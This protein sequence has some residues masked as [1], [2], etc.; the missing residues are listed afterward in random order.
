VILNII[1]YISSVYVFSCSCAVVICNVRTIA[2]R[3]ARSLRTTNVCQDCQLDLIVPKPK[4][5]SNGSFYDIEI[6]CID[7]RT[8]TYEF[9]LLKCSWRRSLLLKF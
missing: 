3:P 9:G 6:Y 5:L 1:Q 8:Q 7:C 4:E 2:N